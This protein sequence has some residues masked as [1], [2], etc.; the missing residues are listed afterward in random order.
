MLDPRTEL[1]G[2]HASWQTPLMA[3]SPLTVLSA[4]S[5]LGGL[6][7]GLEAAGF[8][9]VGCIENDPIARRSLKANRDGWPVLEPAAIEEVAGSFTPT[10]V[11]LK[12]G[13]LTLLAGA[14]PCQPYSKAA[15]WSDN[16][17]SGFADDRAKPL[18]SFLHL[19]EKFQ[20]AAVLMENVQGFVTGRN[21]VANLISGLFEDINRRHRTAYRISTRVLDAADFGVPQRRRRAIIVA[22]RDGSE[23]QWPLVTHGNEPVR[24]WDALHDLPESAEPPKPVGRWASL[25]ASIPEGRNY[26][27][28]TPRGE[29]LPLFGYRTRYWS[30]LL[31]L[32]KGEPSWT[33]P[34]QPGPSVGPF[35]W[36][37]RPLSTEE[38]LRLQSF[39]AT[40]IVEGSRREQ[41][42]QVGNATPPL[43]AEVIGRA[44]LAT[45]EVSDF[46]TLP[47]LLIERVADLPPPTAPAPVPVEFL[48][49]IDDHQDHPG[50]GAGPRPRS[51]AR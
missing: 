23:M 36:D 51:S 21:S 44:L 20:P 37:N 17:W 39:P 6:D 11:G 24:A 8:E 13:E 27:F 41:T 7:L 43:L 35:H 22:L 16:G 26:L 1:S 49:L 29:G 5:G 48:T 31:K 40:W 25:L 2:R 33:L 15:M 30:F 18:L 28:H 4:F 47:S 19:V 12:V 46:N 9:V 3:G 50:T 10:Q 42:R 14:P 38:A 34:A 32:A 45:M